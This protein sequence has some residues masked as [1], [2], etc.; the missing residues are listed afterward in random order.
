M[1]RLP[2]I[3]TARSDVDRAHL[4]RVEDWYARRHAPD[5]IRA[6]FYTAQVYYSEV[7]A[8]RI[9]NLYEIPG[10]ELFVTPAY[11][12]VAAKDTEGPAVIA[13]M[14]SR[15]N[16]IYGQVLTVNVPAPKV[17]WSE[18]HRVGGVGAP[19]LSTVRFEAPG[20]DDGLIVEWYRSREFPRLQGQPGFRA[21]RLCRQ[22]PPHPVAA[23]HDPRWFVIDEWE[24]VAAAVADGSTPEVLARHEGGLRSRLSHFAHNVGHRRFQ[25]DGTTAS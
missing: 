1:A 25:L 19:A 12:D 4:A 13:L 17:D 5:L 11:R 10:P 16:T 3:Y 24:G 15:S 21:G 2:T 23:S 22:G 8:P 7:G 6:G 18:G 9:C 20:V 14:T